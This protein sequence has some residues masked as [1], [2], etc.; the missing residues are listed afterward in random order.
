MPQG[1]PP[2]TKRKRLG[3]LPD[4]RVLTYVILAF[5][6]LML[7]WVIAGAN[8][9]GGTPKNCGSLDAKT[10]NDL[11]S[12]GTGIGVAIL[13]FFWAVIDIILGVV[14]LVTGRSKR[15]CPACGHGAKKGVF[16]CRNCGYDFRQQLT[17]A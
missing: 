4:W 17:R 3:L 15:T 1:Q 2:H 5:N 12:V 8:S 14:Y 10:C 16:A 9:A 6:L 13:I 7:L 11:E